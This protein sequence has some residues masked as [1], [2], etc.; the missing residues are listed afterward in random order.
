MS[1]HLYHWVL[2]SDHC[3]SLRRPRRDGFTWPWVVAPASLP[4]LVGHGPP[5]LRTRRSSLATAALVALA[6]AALI[7]LAR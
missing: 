2:V 6:P 1:F 7:S 5:L 4:A 3:F